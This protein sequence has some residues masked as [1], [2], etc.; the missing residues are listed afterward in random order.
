M[1]VGFLIYGNSPATCGSIQSGVGS[2]ERDKV[3]L[4]V[5]PSSGMRGSH[6]LG[7]Y[8]WFKR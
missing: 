2:G 4:S 3:V 7:D 6:S 1:E 8:F 5:E